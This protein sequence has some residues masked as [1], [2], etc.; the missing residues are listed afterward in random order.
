MSWNEPIGFPNCSRSCA[1]LTAFSYAPI[2]TPVVSHPTRYRVPRSTRAVSRKDWAPDASRLAS[3]TRQ[4][5]SV[6]WPFWTTLSAILFCIFSTLKPG[7]SLFSTMKPLTWLSLTSRAQ[8]IE[9]SHQGALP[10]HRFWPLRTQVSPSRF[11]AA[12]RSGADQRLGQA[13]AADLFHACHRRQ[14]LLFLLLRSSD[15]DRTHRQEVVDAE[16]GRDRGIASRHVHPDKADQQLTPAGAAVPLDAE[17]AELQFLDGRQQLEWESV[18][19]PILV[20]DGR[21]FGV[22]EGAHP[23]EDRKLIGAQG[24]GE[25][26]EVAVRRRQRLRLPD[27]LHGGG[28]GH[29]DSPS[30][31]RRAVCSADLLSRNSMWSERLG[32]LGPQFDETEQDLV[33]LRRQLLD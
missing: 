13:E 8:M 24:L 9:I 18:L 31:L 20:D 15:L 17:A 30:M 5:F 10:I 26:V 33:A 12:T 22:H 27:F 1:Y 3:G 6:I 7:V 29:A 2:W 14:P 16:E 21:D 28:G 4:L 19:G 23:F 11:A 25:V 32:T